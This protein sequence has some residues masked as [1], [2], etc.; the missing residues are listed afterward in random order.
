MHI[1]KSGKQYEKKITA[2]LYGFMIEKQGIISDILFRNDDNGYT[3][4][5][6]ETEE[7]LLTVVGVIPSAVKGMTYRLEG[8]YTMH[9][10]YG[11]QFA[12]LNALQV[13]PVSREG[14]E[15]FLASGLITGIGPK[16]AAAMVSMFGEKTLQVIENEPNKLTRVEGIGKKKASAISNYYHSKRVYADLAIF[17][18]Q[19]GISMN[20]AL[21]LYKHYGADAISVVKSDPYRLIREVHGVGFRKA[22]DIAMSLGLE[23][24]SESR[25][26]A[27]V[28]YGLDFFLNDG[29]VCA[30][31]RE[32]SEKVAVLLD[33][34]REKITDVMAQMS[35][36]MIIRIEEINSIEMVYFYSYYLAEQAVCSNL[37]KL[38]SAELKPLLT[39]IESVTKTT[40]IL[41]DKSLSEKQKT[42]VKKSIDCGVSVITGGPGTGKTTIINTILNIF[43]DSDF[44]V[45]LA[46]PTGRAA[47]RIEETSDHSASTIHKLLGY[48]FSTDLSDIF[49]SRNKDD[50]LEYDAVIVDE[51]S[52]IDLKLM[53]ALTD[54]VLPGTRLIM[55]GDSDQLPSVGAG[56][57]L[58]DIIMS[59]FV[60]TSFL[61]EVFRQAEESMIVVNAHRIN[62]G[63][64]PIVNGSGTDF[65]FMDSNTE[66]D[67]RS[68]L[69]E[70]VSGRLATYYEN[71][72]NL[73]DIQV[74]SPSKKG[75]TGIRELNKALQQALNPSSNEKQEIKSYGNI[76][77]QGDKVMQV[78]NNYDLKWKRLGDKSDGKGV[79]NGD[80]GFIVSIDKDS[81][82]LTV[83]FDEDRYAVYDFDQLDDLELAYAITVHKSQ[84]NEFPIVIMPLCN[85]PPMLATRNLLYTAVTRG[86]KLVVLLGYKRRLMAMVDND[87]I[88]MRYSGL[89]ERL[90]NINKFVVENAHEETERG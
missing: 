12:F 6:M 45:A 87:R 28:E 61:T 27:G 32:L 82:E 23:P 19:H 11:E 34:T 88:K 31:Y 72:D 58:S 79:F 37:L 7:E 21:P 36:E 29:S 39:D 50:P 14:I 22:D 64:Y 73:R 77:R 54:A 10:K 13:M 90:K 76:L 35:M 69:I 8:D 41:T 56:N 75:V 40:E 16:T 51:S 38:N 53:K 71:I 1:K 25:I 42:A 44:K 20:R 2:G 33:L 48:S 86:K 15:K 5:I 55:V 24:D 81:E 47:K 26:R 46:A 63:D 67:T 57:V 30:P 89:A 84:G 80:V 49:F 4:A 60:T 43:D 52:M 66:E 3:V 70:L 83:L 62:R 65:F 18:N 17:L 68:L 85:V 59:G 74:M 9:P 78:R